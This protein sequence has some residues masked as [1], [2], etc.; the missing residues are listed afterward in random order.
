MTSLASLV[1]SRKSHRLP[2]GK[3]WRAWPR[4]L[5]CAVGLML[6]GP[7]YAAPPERTVN[8]PRVELGELLPDAPE[9]MHAIDICD[10]PA[11]GTS[12][13]L[14]RSVITRQVRAAGFD[15]DGL[16]I[17]TSIRITRPGRRYTST[18]LSSLLQGPVSRA[19]PSGVTLLR[20]DTSASPNLEENVAPRPISLPKLPRR[21]GAVRVAFT[22]EFPVSGDV[23]VRVP[24]TATLQIA[25][26]AARSA[27]ARGTKVSLT[28]QRGSARIAADALTLSD[29]DIG[30]ELRFRVAS[31]GKV[32]RGVLVSPTTAIV[33]D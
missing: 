28:I 30:D 29:G 6:S 13:L 23:P 10:S 21:T 20:I 25:S 18:D 7:A 3:G 16:D 33:R 14:E 11:V 31:T 26:D 12:R 24:V 17:P 15:L 22:V 19:L 2:R 8:G 9:F 5:V 32:L 4:L 1:L 27:V